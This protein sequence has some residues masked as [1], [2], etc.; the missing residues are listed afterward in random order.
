VVRL[1][2]VLALNPG[3]L[4]LPGAIAGQ[5]GR[6]NLLVANLGEIGQFD[7]DSVTLRIE[8][9]DA[10]GVTLASRELSLDF[11]NTKVL[12]DVV[13]WAGA[14][15]LDHGQLVVTKAGGAGKFWAIMPV[16]RADGSVSVSN[17][18]IP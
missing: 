6:S 5:A 2:T 4:V 15:D 11:R 9:L 18:F 16:V 8:V 17:G 14:A 13:R 1:A 7:G 10:T 12:A 3:V